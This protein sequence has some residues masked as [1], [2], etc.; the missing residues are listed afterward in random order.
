MES[1]KTP[2]HN[3]DD[4]SLL[5]I[6]SYYR[7]EDEFNWYLRLAWLEL[8]HVC[9]RWRKLIYDT[10]SY[11]DMCLLLTNNSPSIDTLSHLPP[12]P[13]VIHYSNRTRTITRKD[14]DNMHLALQ[15]HDRVRQ[16]I[17]WAPSSSLRMWL[18][19]MNT[20]F[21]R[22][23]HLSLMSTATEEMSLVL[24]E[25]LRAPNLR[26]LSLHG[27]GLPKRLL[28]STIALSTLSLTH[29]Q[30]SC[31][32]PPG[33][34]VTQLQGL[35][36]LEELS[37]GF[38]I[39]IPLPSSEGE[40]LASLILPVT[41]PTQRWITFLGED[42]Y[43][44]N[45][46]AQ[47]NTPFLERLNLT[48]LFDLDFTLANLTEFIHR[49]QGF[50]CLV[51][52]IVFNKDGPFINAGHNEQWDTGK[53]NLQ[54]NCESLDWQ[55]NSATQV[56]SALGEEVLSTVKELTLDLNANGMPPDWENRLDITLWH[57]LL[58]P[59]TGVKK[60]HISS[61]LTLELSRSLESLAGG[62]ILEL[63]PELQVLEVHVDVSHSEKAFSSFVETRESVGRPVDLFYDWRDPIL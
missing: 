7:L 56:C 33:H 55:I 37:V 24:P 22:L 54:V 50:G 31:Y 15:Q 45:L 58:M 11:L 9:P 47:I 6:F 18:E 53:L 20:V 1:K 10:W 42:V 51:A 34:L 28:S 29:I 41:L 57:E 49:T 48:L 59:F 17:L 19:P 12:L 40:L 61:S 60:L 23:G 39:P 30:G 2:I 38:A 43:L 4:D 62:L 27:I 44:D 14:E 25:L 46:V 32:F 3:L 35:P 13:L 16:V 8:V 26:H 36:H 52:R 5:Q 21:S 63:L